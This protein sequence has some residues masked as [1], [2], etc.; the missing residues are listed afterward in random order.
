MNLGQMAFDRYA[1]AAAALD[2]FQFSFHRAMARK[3]RGLDFVR[4]SRLCAAA[5][6][7]EAQA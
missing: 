5:G 6:A 7:S 3:V 2:P 4:V 1:L